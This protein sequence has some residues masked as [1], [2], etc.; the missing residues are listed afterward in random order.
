VDANFYEYNF[1]GMAGELRWVYIGVMRVSRARVYL[2]AAPLLMGLS[3]GASV[4]PLA[5]PDAVAAQRIF[6]AS[7]P[8]DAAAMR[9]S[10]RRDV[11]A[12]PGEFVVFA[13]EVGAD[14]FLAEHAE[15]ADRETNS[16]IVAHGVVGYWEGK[17]L[18]VLPLEPLKSSR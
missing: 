13:T 3:A 6:G 12:H 16:R 1:W 8:D 15:S 7:Y 9:E 14:K 10:L 4:T 18:V 5:R 11:M 17:M 2:Y